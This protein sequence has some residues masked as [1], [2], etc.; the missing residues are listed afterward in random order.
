[1][2]KA[3]SGKYKELEENIATLMKVFQINYGSQVTLVLVFDDSKLVKDEESASAY[4]D[5]DFSMI[6]AVPSF[7]SADDALVSLASA[8]ND[9]D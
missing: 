6:S 1:M 3:I 4:Y 2:K 9:Q 5:K 7:D 8:E